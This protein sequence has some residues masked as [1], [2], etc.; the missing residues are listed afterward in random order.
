MCKTIE[1]AFY[2]LAYSTHEIRAGKIVV[3]MFHAKPKVVVK[4]RYNTAL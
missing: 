2:G 4:R 3:P 1:G